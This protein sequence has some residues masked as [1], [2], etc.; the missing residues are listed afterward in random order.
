MGSS[1]PRRSRPTGSCATPARD[2]SGG[3]LA[4]PDGDPAR[5]IGGPEPV[6][7][8]GSYSP[9]ALK[10]RPVTIAVV[11]VAAVA[12]LSAIGVIVFA[13]SGG[14]SAVEAAPETTAATTTTT[15]PE[16]VAT[17]EPPLPPATVQVVAADESADDDLVATVEA[18]YAWVADPDRPMPDLAPGLAEHLDGAEPP[19]PGSTLRLTAEVF[20]EALADGDQDGDR[21]AVVLVGEDLILAVG[22]GRGWSIV[23][24]RLTGFGLAPWYGEPIRHVFVIGTDARANES[25]PHLRADSLHIV[26]ASLPDQG[27][28]IVGIPRDAYVEASYGFDKFTHVNVRA[29]TGEMVEIAER[30]SGLQIDGYLITGFAGFRKLVNAFGGVAVDV[31]LR[32]NDKDSRADLWPGPQLLKGADALAF[33]RNRKLP[34]GDFTRSF[35]QGVVIDTGLAGTQAKGIESLPRLLRILTASTWTDMAPAQLLQLG[36]IAFEIDA[37]RVANLVLKGTVTTRAGASVVLLS[38]EMEAVFEDLADGVILPTG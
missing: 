27:G 8:T 25:E 38:D 33:T 10:A 26:S 16:T 2:D 20:S 22:D 19:E 11:A 9:L 3:R 21:V 13:G 5:G 36:A 30:L 6:S 18:L 17:T 37:A 28:A 31:P 32:M 4:R 15:V 12:A 29:G 23:G 14:E 7:R 1:T 24:A 34:G 35:H